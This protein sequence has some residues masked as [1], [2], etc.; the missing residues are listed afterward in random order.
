VRGLAP[1]FLGPGLPGCLDSANASRRPTKQ[2]ILEFEPW[3]NSALD[4]AP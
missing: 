2:L 4:A 3:F 1:A